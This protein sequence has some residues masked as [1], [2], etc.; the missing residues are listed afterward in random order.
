MTAGDAR[1]V[2]VLRGRLTAAGCAGDVEFLPNVSREEK[3]QFLHSLDVFSVPATASEAFGLYAIEALAAGVPVVQPR[4]WAFPEIVGEKY[5]VLFEPGSTAENAAAA[6]ADAL[7]ATLRDTA[8]LRL[9]RAG[10]SEVARE[11]YSLG[12]MAAAFAELA[13]SLGAVKR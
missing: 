11:K 9:L 3:V 1:Y 5:G 13:G 8:R 6:L 2:E 7:E 10:A 12:G 4:A